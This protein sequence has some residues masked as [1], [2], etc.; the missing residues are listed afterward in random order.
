MEGVFPD[1]WTVVDKGSDY[2][3]RFASA[4]SSIE[5]LIRPLSRSNSRV[6]VML[7]DVDDF[8]NKLQGKPE[9]F[10]SCPLVFEDVY[11]QKSMNSSQANIQI[12]PY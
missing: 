6:I 11:Q 8:V 12:M 4:G 3:S 5:S 1:D 10:V 2:T 9:R 7:L